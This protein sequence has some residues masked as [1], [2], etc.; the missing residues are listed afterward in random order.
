MEKLTGLQ[1]A[2]AMGDYANT[3]S[4]DKGKEFIEGFIRQH[5]TLQQS[6]FRIILELI[7]H[8]ASPDYQTDLRNEA[9]KKT[10]QKLIAGFKKVI[11]EEEL[12]MGSTPERAKENSESEYMQPSKFLPFI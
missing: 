7:E 12:A 8:M 3:F 9:S 1:L 2:E 11:Y 5:R 10:A 4:R 6:S